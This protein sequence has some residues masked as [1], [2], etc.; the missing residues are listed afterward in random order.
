[1]FW[2][3]I[4]QIHRYWPNFTFTSG[5]EPNEQTG[6]YLDDPHRNSF[7]PCL[8]N[9]AN[10]VMVKGLND[11]NLGELML[12]NVCPVQFPF[13]IGCPEMIWRKNI[14]GSTLILQCRD[15]EGGQFL[16]ILNHRHNCTLKYTSAKI[17]SKNACFPCRERELEW[18]PFQKKTMRI[19]Q[20]LLVA[21]SL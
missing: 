11:L 8:T 17:N 15:D 14:W 19:P 1:M 4:K 3:S 7:R 2:N 6:I 12:E 16:L 18:L 5:N 21:W 10:S 9:N 20:E 13:G